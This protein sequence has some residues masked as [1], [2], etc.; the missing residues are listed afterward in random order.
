MALERRDYRAQLIVAIANKFVLAVVC[1]HIKIKSWNFVHRFTA[2][3][4]GYR[5]PFWT[6]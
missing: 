6:I 5:G 3:T 4:A 2:W 1:H